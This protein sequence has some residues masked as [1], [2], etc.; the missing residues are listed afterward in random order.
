[1]AGSTFGE[2]APLQSELRADRL[3]VRLPATVPAATFAM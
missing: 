2:P 1:M 3:L